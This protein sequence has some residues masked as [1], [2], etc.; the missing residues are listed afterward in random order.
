MRCFKIRYLTDTQASP[1][2]FLFADANADN[3]HPLHMYCLLGAVLRFL[4]C[5]HFYCKLVEAEASFLNSQYRSLHTG[6]GL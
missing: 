2:K 5:Q 1:H 6:N 3:P 4:I